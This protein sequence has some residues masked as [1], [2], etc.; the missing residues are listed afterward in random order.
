MKKILIVFAAVA[1]LT[2]CSSTQDKEA[3][4][5]FCD[6]YTMNDVAEATSLTEIMESAKKMTTCIKTWQSDY[7]GKVSKEGFSDELKEQCPDAHAKADEMG[8]FK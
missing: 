6:C 1:L 8:M 2:S 4:A 7:E 3:A 5:A